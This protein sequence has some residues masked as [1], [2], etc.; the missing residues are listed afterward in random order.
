VKLVFETGTLAGKSVQLPFGETTIG[1]AEDCSLVLGDPSVS[2]YHAE[3]RVI[4]EDRATIRDLG[5]R[6]GTYAD[7]E[8]VSGVWNLAP[9]SELRFGTVVAVLEED[10]RA[11][12]GPAPS[13]GAR[14]PIVVATLALLLAGAAVALTATGSLGG[15]DDDPG[16]R[17]AREPTA[18][19]TQTAT[20]TPTP[21]PFTRQDAIRRARRSTVLVSVDG[22]PNGSGWV[23][24]TGEPGTWVITNE[25]VVAG[26]SEFAVNLDGRQPRPATLFAASACDDLALLRL[27]GGRRLRPLPMGDEPEQGDDLLVMGFPQATTDDIALQVK[28]AI[29]AQTGARLEREDRPADAVYRNLIQVD[30]AVIPGNSGGPLIAAADGSVVGVNTLSEDFQGRETVG[31]AIASSRVQKVLEYLVDGTSVPG[32]SLAFPEDG[33][34]P[35]VVGVTSPTLRRR[36]VVADGTQRVISVAGREFGTELEP[37]LRGLCGLLPEL[38]DGVGDPVTYRFLDADGSTFRA[39]LEY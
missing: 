38:G 34:A 6:N 17:A 1:R 22:F 39:T 9:G 33:T 35:F 28:R 3:I 37:S 11:A 4:A 31:Y 30:G 19:P 25:H 24:D 20:P 21:K 13:R 32:L 27:D 16:A 5:S 18:T 8:R 29:V 26:G 2:G 36:G 15:D 14:L 10:A 23:V 7:G 12:A